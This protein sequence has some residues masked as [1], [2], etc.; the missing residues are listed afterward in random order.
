MDYNQF[1]HLQVRVHVLNPKSITMG[2]LYGEF[3]QQTHEWSDGILSALMRE[4]VEDTTPDKKWYV[5]DGPVDAVWVETMNTLL[6]DNKKLCLT[7]G[8]IIKM[9]PTQTMMFEVQDLAYASPATVSRCGM[10]YME[11]EALGIAPLIKSWLRSQEQQLPAALAGA[12]KATV[13]TLFD[14]WLEPGLQFLRKNLKE[15]VP[16]TDGHLASNLMKILYCM[17][18]PFMHAESEAPQVRYLLC[19]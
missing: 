12:F 8:E 6:D 7:S 4:G 2:Q 1:V 14:A 17:I 19:I 13:Q 15:P 16:T 11:P 18:A 3:D 5:F 9:A 10:I